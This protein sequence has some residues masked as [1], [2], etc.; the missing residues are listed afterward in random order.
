MIED[1]RAYGFVCENDACLAILVVYPHPESPGLPDPF[2]NGVPVGEP[3]WDDSSPACPSCGEQTQ[4]LTGD[5]VDHIIVG[6]KGRY[7]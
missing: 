6:T 3:M 4:L 1:P 7:K 5:P 2:Q